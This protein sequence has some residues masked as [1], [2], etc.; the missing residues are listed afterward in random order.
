MRD[1]RV[2]FLVP[3]GNE[4]IF[5]FNKLRWIYNIAFG[6]NKIVGYPTVA[7]CQIEACRYPGTTAE[8]GH[9][10]WG[11]GCDLITKGS[12]GWMIYGLLVKATSGFGYQD[13]QKSYFC[14]QK[15]AS[16]W[17]F[18]FLSFHIGTTEFLKVTKSITP[19]DILT[20]TLSTWIQISNPWQFDRQ[21]SLEA[22]F[23]PGGGPA[24][25]P[26][27]GL[28]TES[29]ATHA[30]GLSPGSLEGEMSVSRD[31]RVKHC[32]VVKQKTCQ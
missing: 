11:W 20:Q 26:D 8:S 30:S 32:F 27:D 17:R 31:A 12:F 5:Q 9:C 4:L 25:F 24:F 1:L 2:L 15:E 22:P 13:C 19:Q 16:S 29:P 6:S 23:F 7:S 28:A 18:V 3:K 14:E 10:S 21:R